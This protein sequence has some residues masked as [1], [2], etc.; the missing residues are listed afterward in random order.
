MKT[1][2]G[3]LL[4]LS[5]F[6]PAYAANIADELANSEQLSALNQAVS[7]SGIVEDIRESQNVTLFAP[8]DDALQRLPEGFL[9][10]LSGNQDLFT[11]LINNHIAPES[12][13]AEEIPRRDTLQTRAQNSL[14]VKAVE[15]QLY[16]ENA[17]VVETIQA[18]NGI[19]HVVDRVLI[20]PS[21]FD[22]EP[23]NGNGDGDGDD[24][25]GE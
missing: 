3:A 10:Y 21:L 11:E 15:N 7:D 5:T 9:E 19:I 24:N 16:L 12:L 20:A 17:R 8:S 25:N 22:Q 23:N 6:I 4:L 14:Q 2:I 13:S 1:I 18:D